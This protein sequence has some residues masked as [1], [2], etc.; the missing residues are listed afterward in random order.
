LIF[1]KVLLYPSLGPV[2]PNLPS[3]VAVNESWARLLLL[4]IPLWNAFCCNLH[5]VVG[6][7]T[8][9]YL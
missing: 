6:I 5:L 3:N 2:G 8:P 1:S 9:V 4:R 7:L